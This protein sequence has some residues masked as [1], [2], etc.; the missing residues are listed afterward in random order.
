[1]SAGLR[2]GQWDLNIHDFLKAPLLIPSTVE[3]KEIVVYL[4]KRCA[5]IDKLVVEKQ[6]IIEE[7]KA[8]KKSLIF[9]YVTGKKEVA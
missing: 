8:Y 3:Q 4:D 2:I 9:E 7:L 6:E 1:M 5:E